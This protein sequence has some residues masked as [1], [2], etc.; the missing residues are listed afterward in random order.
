MSPNNAHLECT[1]L[2]GLW[3]QIRVARISFQFAWNFPILCRIQSHLPFHLK[4]IKT[5]LRVHPQWYVVALSSNSKW[6]FLFPWLITVVAVPSDLS[7]LVTYVDYAHRILLRIC[8]QKCCGTLACAESPPSSTAACA[9]S[10]SCAQTQTAQHLNTSSGTLEKLWLLAE[11][12]FEF[13]FGPSGMISFFKSGSWLIPVGGPAPGCFGC[14][15]FLPRFVS[16]WI[17]NLALQPLHRFSLAPVCIPELRVQPW[18]WLSPL[19]SNNTCNQRAHSTFCQE[20]KPTVSSSS[21][22]HN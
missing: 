13:F 11:Y 8:T 15:S 10:S 21:A 19:Q 14:L 7:S 18:L 17:L 16:N 4:I 1:V 5:M 20:S 2:E 22:L 3:R 12:I 9:P 6:G